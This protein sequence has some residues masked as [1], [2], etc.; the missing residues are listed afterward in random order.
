MNAGFFIFAFTLVALISLRLITKKG[1]NYSEQDPLTFKS[2]IVRRVSI[3]IY[4]S[5]I[6]SGIILMSALYVILS[7]SY[8][9]S[10][11]KWAFGSIGCILGFWTRGK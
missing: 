8:D 3:D 11:Q 9:E 5:F 2:K 1:K 4:L 6:I 10:T 7:N